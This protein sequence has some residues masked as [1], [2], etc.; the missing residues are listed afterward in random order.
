VHA[1]ELK[2]F[3]PEG[4]EIVMMLDAKEGCRVFTS[5]KPHAGGWEHE[6]LIPSFRLIHQGE[7][8]LE[9]QPIRSRTSR[10]A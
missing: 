1:A 9:Y 8:A 7:H 4:Q 5:S 3:I 10:A 6:I 2:A